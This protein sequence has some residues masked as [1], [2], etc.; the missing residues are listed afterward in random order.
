MSSKQKSENTSWIIP[1][2]D[3]NTYEDNTAIMAGY[4]GVNL[5]TRPDLFQEET[6]YERRS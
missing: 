2:T 4:T 3:A 6:N 5:E 1:A